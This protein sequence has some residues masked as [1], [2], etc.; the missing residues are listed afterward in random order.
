MAQPITSHDEDDEDPVVPPKATPKATFPQLPSVEESP[1]REESSVFGLSVT[2]EGLALQKMKD[3]LLMKLSDHDKILNQ[4]LQKLGQGG[5]AQDLRGRGVKVVDFGLRQQ[6]DDSACSKAVA[7]GS[8]EMPPMRPDA[9]EQ[10]AHYEKKDAFARPTFTP[11][12]FSTFTQFELDKQEEAYAVDG[13]VSRVLYSQD[14]KTTSTQPRGTWVS[15]MVKHTFFDLFCAFVIITNSIF[16]GVEVELTIAQPESFQQGVHVIQYVYAAWFLLELILRVY[17][18]GRG[19]FC[20]E[21]WLWGMLDVF[22]VMSSIWELAVDIVYALHQ[23]G[24]GG[25]TSVSGLKALRII[26]ITR[27]LAA[28]S[29]E[30]MLPPGS[31]MKRSSTPVGFAVFDVCLLRDYKGLVHSLSCFRL[32]PCHARLVS[33]RVSHWFPRFSACLCCPACALCLGRLQLPVPSDR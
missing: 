15:R 12:L 9:Q 10:E 23:D 8:H 5:L 6:S 3:E 17:V 32:G 22:V 29:S 2:D 25:V 33:P 24:P 18:D 13:A 20:G 27:V 7:G 4:I 19:F 21:D 11:A 30:R 26:R 1:H 16:L 14:A 31:S 28:M